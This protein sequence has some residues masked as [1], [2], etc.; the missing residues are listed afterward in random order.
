MAIND[1]TKQMIKKTEKKITPQIISKK[2]FAPYG[3]LLTGSI[4][5]PNYKGKGWSSLFPAASCH[6]PNGEI[7]WVVTK[8]QKQ[9]VITGMERE[10]EVEV[11]WPTNGPII[12]TVDLPGNLKDHTQQPNI[13]S[14][15]AFVVNPGQVIVMRPGTWHAPAFPAGKNQVLYYFITK[16]HPREPGW[17][18]TPWIPFSSE[19]KIIL[20]NKN[21]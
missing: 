12:Q 1:K 3:Q 16:D 11:I 2:A 17:E 5:K 14:V 15:K 19:D 21:K 20:I 13:D 6:L 8:P 7:G 4:G 10:P 18:N 9:Y